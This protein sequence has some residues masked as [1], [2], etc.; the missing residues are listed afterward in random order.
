MKKDFICI[1]AY[2]ILASGEIV[3]IKHYLSDSLSPEDE[4][5][6]GLKF[7]GSKGYSIK[8]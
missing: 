3:Y 8:C 5:E 7:K 4:K 6:L 2:E 1:S